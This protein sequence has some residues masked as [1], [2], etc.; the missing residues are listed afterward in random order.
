MGGKNVVLNHNLNT[1]KS[2]QRWIS[3]T[4]IFPNTEKQIC[5]NIFIGFEAILVM[6]WDASSWLCVQ[7]TIYDAEEE[8]GV[9][10]MQLCKANALIP[11]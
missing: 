3:I 9:I 10:Y 2:Q 1:T 11:L 4:W 5:K 7:D 6:L 8:T